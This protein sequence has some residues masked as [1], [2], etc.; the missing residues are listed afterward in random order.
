L[1]ESILLRLAQEPFAGILQKLPVP[2][3]AQSAIFVREE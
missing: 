1:T 2:S 3:V